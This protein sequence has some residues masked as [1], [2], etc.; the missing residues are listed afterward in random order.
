MKIKFL[1][2]FAIGIFAFSA[3]NQKAPELTPD[4][5]KQI[6]KEAYIYAYPMMENYKMIYVLKVWKDSP[7]YETPFNELTHNAVLLG[8]EYTTM[9]RP[10]NDTFY[11]NVIFDLRAEPMI[12]SVPAI[13]DNRY[14]SWQ[15]ID[16]F[17]HNVGYVGTRATGFEAGKYL[18]AGPDWSGKSLKG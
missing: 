11:S 5:A 16:L 18:I 9:V 7:V 4:E 6:T 10:N 8:P 1:V 15:L 12:L 14:Y 13:S 2:V 3:C 17:T